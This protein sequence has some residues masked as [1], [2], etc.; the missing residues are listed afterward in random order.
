MNERQSP[1]VDRPRTVRSPIR[2]AFVAT[3]A[4]S[5]AVSIVQLWRTTSGHDTYALAMLTLAEASATIGFQAD[6]GLSVRQEYGDTAVAS[7]A[8]IAAHGPWRAL[9]EGLL[10]S[11][12]SAAW[13][14]PSLPLRAAVPAT[15]TAA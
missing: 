4:L 8:N 15:G 3:A 9:C 11:V 13:L 5:V 12:L 7:I 10:D 1:V 14:C 2:T 6:A